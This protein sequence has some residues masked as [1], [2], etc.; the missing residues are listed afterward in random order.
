MGYLVEISKKIQNHDS[1]EEFKSTM[2]DLAE[3]YNSSFYYF[4]YELMGRNRQVYRNHIVVT[5]LLPEDIESVVEFIRLIKSTRYLYIESIGY[6]NCVYKLI[7]ASK[8]YLRMMD[9]YFAK[10]YLKK[11]KSG[12]LLKSNPEI[13]SEMFVH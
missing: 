4:N 5:I 3:N 8:K 13:L 7:F 11:K 2:S 6:D 12:L 9:D 1:I 10:D